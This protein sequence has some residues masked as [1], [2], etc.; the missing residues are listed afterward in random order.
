[1]FGL[2]RA[3]KCGLSA[4]EKNFR[5]LNYCGTCKTI[6]AVYGQKARLLLNHDTVFLAEILTALSGENVSER[7]KSYQ[8][9]NCLSLPEGEMPAA[10]RF[11]AAANLILTKFKLADHIADE[12][13]TR[14]RF[15]GKAFAGEFKT[16]AEFLKDCG[17]PLEDVEKI[18]QKQEAVENNDSDLE[19]FSK[20]TAAATGMF[21]RE[22]V[23]LIG[24]DELKDTA[25]NFG[26]SFG[27][28]VYL[29]DAFEDYE[30][31]LQKGK[32][33]A[34][35]KA[36]GLEEKKLSASAKRRIKALF[37]GLETEIIAHLY[38]LPLP[39]NQ[40]I[41]FANRLSENLRKQLGTDLPVLKAQK[42]CAAKPKQTFSERWTNA[43]EKARTLAGNY[44]WQ[45]PAVFLFIL[46]FAFVAPAQTR[47]AK[48]ARECFD[49]GFNLMFLGSIIGSVAAL[50]RPIFSQ[51]PGRIYPEL[52]KKKPNQPQQQDDSGGGW[53]DS[54]DCG[55]V[56]CCDCSECCCDCGGCCDGGC[57]DSC[58]CCSCDC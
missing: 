30:K 51:D 47:D 4:E 40:K 9:Y 53:C 49:L 20:P 36:F 3:K 57:C 50:N 48:S 39:E 56:D 55:C 28:L 35:R 34:F 19:D 18:L 37:N 21:F 27:K 54:C 26:F 1:M 45:M 46:A 29:V 58:D 5:R 41:V 10:L 52:Q 17:F 2:M 13:K 25:Y 42:A 22:G 44:S 15:A 43:L 24:K 14:Y 11:A 8:S 23:R 31:D 7:Q 32:F 38:E 33:N 12:K 16:A 6:G